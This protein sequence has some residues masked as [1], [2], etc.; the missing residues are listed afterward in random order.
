V[1]NI[2][3]AHPYFPLVAVSGIDTTVKLFGPT[4]TRSIFSRMDNAEQILETNERL[5]FTSTVEYSLNALLMTRAR[6]IGLGDGFDRES[7][8]IGQ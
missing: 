2:I 5:N 7:E 8:C 6:S 1:V 3:E 4:Y